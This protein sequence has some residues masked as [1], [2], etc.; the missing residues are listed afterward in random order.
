MQ[1]ERCLRMILKAYFLVYSHRENLNVCWLLAHRQWP[2]WTWALGNIVA[3]LL[4][5][6]EYR[7]KLTQFLQQ[8]VASIVCSGRKTWSKW[9]NKWWIGLATLSPLPPASADESMRESKWR[10]WW[11]LSHIYSNTNCLMNTRVSMAAVATTA[12]QW[13]L[14]WMLRCEVATGIRCCF[15]FFSQIHLLYLYFKLLQISNYETTCFPSWLNVCVCVCLFE[16][17]TML[18]YADM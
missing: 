5:P 6:L 15:F 18:H 17:H 4:F 8:I 11:R 14:C 10:Y 13:L 7:E 9:I 2:T 16:R 1:T 3:Y 12:A